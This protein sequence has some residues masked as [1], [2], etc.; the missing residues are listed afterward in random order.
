MYIQ[1]L[2]IYTCIHIYTHT[3][4]YIYICMQAQL[5][6]CDW[7]RSDSAWPPSWR[8][9]VSPSL[10]VDGCGSL[11][12]HRK[13]GNMSVVLLQHRCNQFILLYRIQNMQN[14]VHF[15]HVY[16]YICSSY[17][18]HSD[19]SYVNHIFMHVFNTFIAERGSQ[20]C[21]SQKIKFNHESRVR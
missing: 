4:I 7:R 8:S 3:R 17:V 10:W 12:G 20:P 18:H 21:N 9:A 13:H 5:A 11:D 6:S 15:F 14:N 19:M 16:M 2:Y 1:I